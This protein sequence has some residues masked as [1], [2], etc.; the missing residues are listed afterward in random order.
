MRCKLSLHPVIL[1]KPPSRPPHQAVEHEG[2]LKLHLWIASSVFRDRRQAARNRIGFVVYKSNQL[3]SQVYGCFLCKC[4]MSLVVGTLFF[5]ESCFPLMQ[6]TFLL[7]LFLHQL[8]PCKVS[9][10]WVSLC[11]APSL[12][13]ER[14]LHLRSQHAS[15]GRLFAGWG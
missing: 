9:L 1:L 7:C 2:N 14:E 3:C 13:P 11:T 15:L 5:P 12:A 10:C 8:L 6:P 4:Q